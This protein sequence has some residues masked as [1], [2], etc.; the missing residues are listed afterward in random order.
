M[1]SKATTVDAWMKAV[2][3]E[4]LAAIKRLRE[5]C[6]R[7]LKGYEE[8]MDYGMPGY[9]LDG[10]PQVG[11]NSQKQYIALYLMNTDLVDE[12][13]EQLNASSIG[14]CCI[15]YNRA[16]KMDFAAIERLLERVAAVS[17]TAPSRSRL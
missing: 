12:F 2:A 11:F 16:E 17:S 4:R 1:I 10:Q 6:R 3:P 5:V 13:R 14:K 8:A 15:R 7:T 9:K